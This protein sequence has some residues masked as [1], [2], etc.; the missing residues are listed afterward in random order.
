MSEKKTIYQLPSEPM[1]T[2]ST[3]QKRFRTL[4]FMAYLEYHNPKT[5]EDISKHLQ[6]FSEEYR[7][8][9]RILVNE[10]M[11]YGVKYLILKLNEELQK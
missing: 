3:G 4:K 6:R 9:F 10:L 1:K 8:D 11:Q 5:P 2:E 7:V